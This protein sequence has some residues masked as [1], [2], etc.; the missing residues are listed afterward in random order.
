MI[1]QR[2]RKDYTGEFIITQT[3]WSG[4]KKRTQREWIANPIENHHISGRAAC[5]AG[6][7]DG[8][9]FDYKLLQRHKGGL[10][11][12]KKL[13]TY[14]TGE[15]AEH[16]RLDFTVEKDSDLITQLVHKNYFKENIVY[17]TPRNCIKYPGVFYTIPYN[18]GVIKQVALAYLAAFDGHSE[19]FLLGYHDDANL[20]HDSWHSQMEQVI[21]A[22]PACKF[23]H[24]AFA[25]QTPKSWLNY[26]NLVPMTHREFIHYADI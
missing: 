26:S 23:Y 3:S 17:T 20:G 1:A 12:S 21:A 13:Q 16:M 24:V 4:G 10:L 7:A 19:I 6:T 22:Y 11:S 5:I 14:G 2:Y 8:V 25:P 15:L 9:H 18:P